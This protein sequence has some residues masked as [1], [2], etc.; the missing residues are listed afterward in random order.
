MQ[1]NLRVLPRGT[2]FLSAPAEPLNVVKLPPSHADRLS[3]ALLSASIAARDFAMSN[4]P[5]DQAQRERYV[6]LADVLEAQR[7]SLRAEV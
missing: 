5:W 3:V 1:S 7:R 6:T 2:T 4:E